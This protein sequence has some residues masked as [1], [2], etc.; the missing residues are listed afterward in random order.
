[1]TYDVIDLFSGPDG[2]GT[3]FRQT[4]SP[5]SVLG[6]EIEP[7]ARETAMANG[8]KTILQDIATLEPQHYGH[9]GELKGLIASPPCQGFSAAGKGKGREDADRLIAGIAEI[10][11]GYEPD[12]V[13]ATLHKDMADDRSVLALEPLRW[14][15]SLRPEW[16]VWE[17]VPAVLPIWEACAAV[18]RDE[19]YSVWVGKMN[20]ERYG[21]PQTRTRA[22]LIASRTKQVA[23]PKATHSK[24]Y[25]REPDRIDPGVSKWV[26]MA[27]ALGWTD[28]VVGFPRK[29]DGKDE[30]LIDGQAYRARDMRETG[31]P[32]QV[33]TEKARSWQYVNG[34]Q[35][36][37]ARRSLDTPAPTVHF[38]ARSNKVEF[39]FCGAGVTSEQSTVRDED[40]P[41]ATIHAGNHG[42]VGSIKAP[43]YFV[44]TSGH[45][46]RPRR[47]DGS[48]LV[49]EG[50]VDYYIRIPTDRPCPTLTSGSDG[51]KWDDAEPASEISYRTTED[52]TSRRV[53]VQE[54]AI[55]QSF[56][57]DYVWCGSKTSQF[58]QVGNAIPPLLAQRILEVVL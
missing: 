20:S 1:M 52:T 11:E 26:S 45:R 25:S 9:T 40:A 48:L 42:H 24:Y 8:H 15:I 57:A 46:H 54:A 31:K 37:S 17:Q 23:E 22:I 49:R 56:P 7:N 43:E 29:S 16:T 13:I 4:G 10:G 51:A 41:A 28:G 38:G 27:E 34:N 58:Q 12:D 50:D 3:G 55:L 36:N 21:V 33:V 19:G 44:H 30:I 6:I 5:L 39:Q 35:A 18:L 32:A 2:W 47:E 53:T 14:A